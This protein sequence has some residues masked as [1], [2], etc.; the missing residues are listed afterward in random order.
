MAIKMVL[1]RA[2]EDEYMRP[3]PRPGCG[4]CGGEVPRR[5]CYPQL[6]MQMPISAVCPRKF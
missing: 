1:Q 3:D 5:T 2:L 6:V 4:N